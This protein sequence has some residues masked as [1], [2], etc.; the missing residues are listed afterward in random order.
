MRQFLAFAAL[1]GCMGMASFAQAAAVSSA[2]DLAFGEKQLHASFDFTASAVL[3]KVEVAGQEVPALLSRCVTEV[4]GALRCSHANETLRLEVYPRFGVDQQ[5]ESLRV[6][7][8]NED[9]TT[10]LYE[11][12]TCR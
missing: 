7:S 6:I 2:C 10:V 3:S 12:K 11:N 8:W 9:G 1:I 5:V 4:R